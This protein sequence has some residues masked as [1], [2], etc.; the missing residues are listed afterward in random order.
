MNQCQGLESALEGYRIS[1]DT[2]WAVFYRRSPLLIR[3]EGG[4]SVGCGF[5]LAAPAATG[6][7]QIKKIETRDCNFLRC[8]SLDDLEALLCDLNGAPCASSEHMSDC[9]GL[10]SPSFI[11]F[12]QEGTHSEIHRVHAPSLEEAMTRVE[13][14]YPGSE[15]VFGD[16]ESEFKDT[17]FHMRQIVRAQ[18]FHKI[19]ADRRG[20]IG[21]YDAEDLL[22]AKQRANDPAQS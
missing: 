13:I 10:F 3:L 19:S 20:M 14:D 17:I 1:A 8:F 22:F 7:S 18:A 21:S 5:C 12:R 2:L 4:G 16:S 6:L 15:A 11:V 9:F